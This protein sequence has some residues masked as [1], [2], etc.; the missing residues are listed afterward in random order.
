[1][2]DAQITYRL[3]D[4]TSARE[5]VQWKYPPPYDVYNNPEEKIGDAVHYNIDPANNVYAMFDQADEL[6]GYCSYGQDAQVP[7]G[8]YSEDALD[9]GLMLKPELTGQGMGAD[10]AREV[11]HNGIRL[12]GS[13]KIRV[14]IAAFNK[15]AIRTWENNG[16]RQTQRFKRINDDMEFIV[17][18]LQFRL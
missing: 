13:G 2:S 18:V 11:I 5:F 15:R 9:I 10:F 6:I 1:M 14:T 16:F 17:M 4:K 7:G 12:F 8:D 3:A